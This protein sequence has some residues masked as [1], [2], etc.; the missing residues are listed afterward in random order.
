MF[1]IMLGKYSQTQTA[2]IRTVRGPRKASAL[3]ECP[4]LSQKYTFYL[5]KKTKEL[6][7]DISSV[8]LNLSNFQ[9]AIIP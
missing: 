9:K 2:L 7:Q 6:K 8:K 1:D 5:K 4:Y 3:T